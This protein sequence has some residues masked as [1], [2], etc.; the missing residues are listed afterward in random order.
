[1]TTI[2]DTS[3]PAFPAECP[4]GNFFAGM[5]LRDYFAIHASGNDLVPFEHV[6]DPSGMGRTKN[7]TRAEARYAFA[8]DMLKARNQ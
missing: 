2:T 7:R 8:D 4:E 6:P 5:T 3:G 1:M